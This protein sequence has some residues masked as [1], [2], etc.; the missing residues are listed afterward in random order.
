MV[1]KAREYVGTPHHHSGRDC[2]G[3]DCAGLLY[4]VFK[5]LGLPLRPIPMYGRI[6]D[7]NFLIERVEENFSLVPGHLDD[8]IPGDIL[9]IRFNKTPQHV[10]ILTEGKIIHSYEKA[11]QVVEQRLNDMWKSRVAGVYRNV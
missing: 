8:A 10:A 1:S 5:D 6:V 2:N 9:M 4:C 3:V 11:G 7:P